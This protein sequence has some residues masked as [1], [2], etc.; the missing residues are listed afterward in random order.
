M[1][2]EWRER[3]EEEEREEKMS[4]RDWMRRGEDVS[5]SEIVMGELKEGG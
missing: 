5:I 2:R 3:G 4:Q 1:K